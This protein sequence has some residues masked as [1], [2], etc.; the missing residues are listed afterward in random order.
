MA[1]KVL[2]AKWKN[3]IDILLLQYGNHS[4]YLDSTH[5]TAGLYDSVLCTVMVKNNWSIG[6]CYSCVEIFYV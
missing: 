2:S 3:I 4:I 5:G 1:L 6:N